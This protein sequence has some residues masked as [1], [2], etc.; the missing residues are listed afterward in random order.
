MYNTYLDIESLNTLISNAHKRRPFVLTENVS[1]TFLLIEKHKE[2]ERKIDGRRF[3]YF[4]L[5]T[6]MCQ[7]AINQDFFFLNFLKC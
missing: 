1:S 3:K 5:G 4:P 7:C 6:L 2:Q